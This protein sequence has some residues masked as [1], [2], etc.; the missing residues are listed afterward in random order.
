MWSVTL[1]GDGPMRTKITANES[2]GGM[3]SKIETRDTATVVVQGKNFIARDIGIENSAGPEMHQAL[4]LLVEAEQ[5]VFYNC[6]IDGYQDTLS[7]NKGSQFYRDCAI[8]GTVDFIFGDGKVVFQNCTLQVRKPLQDQLCMVTAQGRA[9]ANG[10][11]GFVMQNCRIV[12]APDYPTKD[13]YFRTF[14]GRPWRPFA[15][16]VVLDSYLDSIIDPMGWSDWNTTTNYL[17]TCWFREFGSHGPGGNTT[18]RIK[19]P[20]VKPMSQI[21]AAQFTPIRFFGDDQWILRSLVPYNPS[22]I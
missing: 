7:P 13:K 3:S 16:T 14:L 15:R 18:Q 11:T 22:W 20:G 19:S 12:P 2:K 6:R 4:A 9:I 17:N 10:D 5:S 1:C 21:F 8:S